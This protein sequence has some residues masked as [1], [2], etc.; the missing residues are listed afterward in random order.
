[1]FHRVPSF[2]LKQLCATSSYVKDFMYLNPEVYK[3]N[4]KVPQEDVDLYI[5]NFVCRIFLEIQNN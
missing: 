1:M 5:P 3:I 2:G 4:I